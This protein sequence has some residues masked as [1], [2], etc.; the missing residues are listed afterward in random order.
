MVVCEGKMVCVTDKLILRVEGGKGKCNECVRGR[1]GEGGEGGG[2]DEARDHCSGGRVG[3]HDH[4]HPPT[5]TQTP[6]SG[7]TPPARRLAVGSPGDKQ[8][9]GVDDIVHTPGDPLHEVSLDSAGVVDNVIFGV[10][11]PSASS[12]LRAPGEG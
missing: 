6:P 9:C 2:R 12:A 4:I 7:I 3:H 8:G 5:H 10:A 1:G 11:R